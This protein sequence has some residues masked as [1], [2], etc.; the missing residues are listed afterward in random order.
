[1]A[2][3]STVADPV[4]MV[5]YQASANSTIELPNKEKAWLIHKIKNFFIS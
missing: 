5:K 2:V 4:F 3:A 1:M